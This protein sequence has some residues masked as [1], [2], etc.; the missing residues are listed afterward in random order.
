MN[1]EGMHARPLKTRPLIPPKDNLLA[2][3]DEA[4]T[5]LSEQSVVAISSK[6]VAI[7][8]GRCIGKPNDIDDPLVYKDELAAFEADYYIPRGEGTDHHRM[9]TIK[10]GVL[11][12]A[13]GVDQSN[14]NGYFVLWP[15]E[16]MEAA[17]E[18]RA[19]LQKRH[20]I[21][22]LGVIITDS[23]STPLRNGAVG[24]TLGYAGFKAQYDY[25]GSEDIFGKAFNAERLNVADTLAS[26]ANLV[27][28]EGAET[29]PFAI[30]TGAPHVQFS[31]S[32]EKHPWLQLKIPLAEDAFKRFFDDQPWQAGEKQKQRAERDQNEL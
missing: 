18:L 29:T 2:V 31:E 27:M 20:N 3:M 32:E 25:R 13:A 15:R 19:H 6:V 30:I 16:P 7:W 8:Q 23:Q 9:H 10:D 28:G 24:I 26:T 14:G 12:G 21:K 4:I 17:R 5:E 22:E 11:I 1:T